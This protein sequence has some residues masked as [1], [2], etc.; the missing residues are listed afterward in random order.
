[1]RKIGEHCEYPELVRMRG[2]ILLAYDKNKASRDN[3]VFVE[4]VEIA[5]HVLARIEAGEAV[6]DILDMQPEELLRAVRGD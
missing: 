5:G 2:Q 1:M 3:L 6:G 4:P